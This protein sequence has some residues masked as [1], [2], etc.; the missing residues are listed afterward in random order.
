[1]Y[2]NM[3][4]NVG[5]YEGGKKEKVIIFIYGVI[6]EFSSGRVR[7]EKKVD[8]LIHQVIIYEVIMITFHLLLCILRHTDRK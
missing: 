2:T 6:L 1:M 4:T 8:V 7:N 5:Y 3:Y